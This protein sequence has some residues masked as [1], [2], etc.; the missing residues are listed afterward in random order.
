MTTTGSS[1]ASVTIKETFIGVVVVSVHVENKTTRVHLSPF[2][3][4]QKKTT[5]SI[6]ASY[7]RS[8]SSGLF[9]TIKN[10]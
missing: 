3:F 7:G 2:Q 1:I 6:L 10:C 5:A 9:L 8:K 4:E